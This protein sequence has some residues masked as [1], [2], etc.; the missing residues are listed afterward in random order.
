[1]AHFAQL[2]D[3]NFVSQVIVVA[4]EKCLDQNG[5]EN[6]AIGALFCH[7]LLGGRWIQTSY[8][9]NFRKNY[10][11][12]N[13]FY[14]ENKDAFIAPKPYESW[15]LNED[16]CKWEAPIAYPQDGNDYYWDETTMEWK[17]N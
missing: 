3:E 13:F 1:M 17:K 9:S 4:N 8:N 14:D 15:L 5:N 12:I 7:Q 6:E 2:T 16:T 10:A 11:G